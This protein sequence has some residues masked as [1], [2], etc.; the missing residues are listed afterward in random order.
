MLLKVKFRKNFT[1]DWSHPYPV[2]LNFHLFIGFA[3][4]CEVPHSSW[5]PKDIF[6]FVMQ[7]LQCELSVYDNFSFQFRPGYTTFPIPL[8]WTSCR[9]LPSKWNVGHRAI[10]CPLS[11]GPGRIT[12]YPAGS[13][14]FP[15]WPWSFNMQIDILLDSISVQQTTVLDSQTHVTLFSMFYVS[16]GILERQYCQAF[17]Q[18][19][20]ISNAVNN[21]NVIT[22]Y[23]NKKTNISRAFKR[24]SQKL[25]FK[26]FQYFLQF[27]RSTS[28]VVFPRNHS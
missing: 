16:S 11:P 25:Q 22:V 18:I 8:R 23:S 17:N 9:A 13:G 28:H 3:F 27:S 20:Y 2:S 21:D 14:L 7:L 26:F 15:A 5:R 12:C 1:N 6:M 4:L 24:F 19:K 10:R